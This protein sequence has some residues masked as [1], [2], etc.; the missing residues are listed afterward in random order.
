MIPGG[1]IHE[2]FSDNIFG[3]MPEYNDSTIESTLR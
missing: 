1:I 3:T 2:F